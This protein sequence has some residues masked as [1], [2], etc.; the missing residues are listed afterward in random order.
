[1]TLI[2]ESGIGLASAESYIS[3]ADADAYHA[4]FGNTAWAAIAT[5]ALKEAYLRRATI[6]MGQAYR[7]RWSGVRRT[8]TQA[9]DWP[10]T[11]VVIDRFTYVGYDIVPTDVARACADLALK[12][13]DADLNADLERAVIREKVGPLETEY[14]EHSPQSTRYRAI[15]QTLAPY[16]MGSGASA[17]LVRA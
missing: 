11:E 1:M 12:A 9:L 13:K 4:A 7:T 16:L 15:D 8:T 17:R 10:R 2:V 3:V 14:S 6:Y 5:T